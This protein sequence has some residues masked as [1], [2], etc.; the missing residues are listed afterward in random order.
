MALLHFPCVLCFPDDD[1][2][3]CGQ[4]HRVLY[5]AYV[6]AYAFGAADTFASEIGVLSRAPPRMVG[7][8]RVVP[9][10]TNGGVSALGTAAAALGGLLVGASGSLSFRVPDGLCF[11]WS[12]ALT[13][14]VVGLAGTTLDSVL[15]ATLQY[16]GAKP[17]P[18]SPGGGVV[19]V[20]A[21]GKDVQHIAGRNVLSNTGV[22]FVACLASAL[23]APL[24]CCT[25]LF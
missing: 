20:A 5:L 9:R 10:G 1:E 24:L 8:W 18:G 6:G 4:W 11:D 22:N 7:S 23:L 15:G 12:V 19:V 13:G 16:S 2:V 3:V 14:L 17:A 21:P 25:T